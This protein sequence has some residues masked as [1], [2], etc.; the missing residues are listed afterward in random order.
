MGLNYLFTERD[1]CPPA[2]SH[3]PLIPSL[4][5]SVLRLS[6]LPV[7]STIHADA[8]KPHTS[9]SGHAEAV[10]MR[11]LTFPGWEVLMMDGRARWVTDLACASWL[12]PLRLLKASS[13]SSPSLH[14]H[15]R[16]HSRTS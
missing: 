10:A 9:T 12:T 11:D 1:A 13:R 8:F 7:S 4:H 5:L 14:R 6:S 2:A 3:F 16:G 15:P